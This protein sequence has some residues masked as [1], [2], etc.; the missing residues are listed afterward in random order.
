MKSKKYLIFALV[1]ILIGS[2]NQLTG[3]ASN[4]EF[5]NDD[6]IRLLMDDLYMPSLS[7]GIID[8]DELIW[9]GEYGSYKDY[10]NFLVPKEEKTPTKDTVYM[11]GSISKTVTAT[12]MMQLYEKGLYNL[13]D[14]VSDHLGFDLIN[15]LKGK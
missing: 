5:D 14:T 15:L 12:A 11:T 8:K 9:H 10:H 13:S 1:F 3:E 2:S 4:D 7:A 6:N